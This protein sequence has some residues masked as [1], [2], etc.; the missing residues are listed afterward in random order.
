MFKGNGAKTKKMWQKSGIFFFWL[1]GDD[2][3]Q[4][5]KNVLYQ[6]EIDIDPRYVQFPKGLVDSLEHQCCLT[7][8][9]LGQYP[10]LHDS[11]KTDNRFATNKMSWLSSH[12]EL[13]NQIGFV[14]LFTWQVHS[15]AN[16]FGVPVV[17]LIMSVRAMPKHFPQLSEQVYSLI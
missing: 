17:L 14:A 2:L 12:V 13:V 3:W 5:S 8:C 10:S 16:Y 6:L 11:S 4:L 1:S 9:V 7:T 15:M